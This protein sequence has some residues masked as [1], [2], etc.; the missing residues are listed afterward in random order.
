MAS[1]NFSKGKVES[2]IEFTE[3]IPVASASIAGLNNPH[4]EPTK[5]ISLTTVGV[6]SR[7][8]LDAIVDFKTTVPRGFINFIVS[9]NPELLP[10][11]STTRSNDCSSDDSMPIFILTPMF[12][13]L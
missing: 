11:A 9:A 7:F 12:I 13:R 6:R 4:L 2:I 5:V 10:V 1:E 3:T 8:S